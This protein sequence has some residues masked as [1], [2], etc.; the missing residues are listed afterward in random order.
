MMGLP[1]DPKFYS[2]SKALTHNEEF[3][4][5]ADSRVLLL[6]CM[7]KDKHETVYFMLHVSFL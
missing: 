4:V 2:D 5:D 6:K 1:Q 3:G 7:Q